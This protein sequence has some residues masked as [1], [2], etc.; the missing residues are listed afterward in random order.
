MLGLQ[1]CDID[2]NSGK[3]HVRRGYSDG[4]FTEPKSRHS[5]RQVDLPPSLLNELRRWKLACPTGELDLVFPNG[6][7]M[8][9]SPSNLLE[10]GFYPALR[11]A[12]LRQVRFPDLRH[13]YASC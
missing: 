3:V 8:P 13:T 4:R 7:G 12:G 6:Q 9:E 10:Y 11:R 5:R 1:W 2:W